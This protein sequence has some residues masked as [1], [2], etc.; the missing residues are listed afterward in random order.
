MKIFNLTRNQLIAR[1]GKAARTYFERFRGLI[2][3]KCF[4]EDDG[5]WIPKCQG[6]HTFGM[7]FPIDVVFLD[8]RKKVVGI[9]KD[10][11]P[12]CVGPVFLAAHSVLEFAAGTIERCRIRMGDHFSLIEDQPGVQA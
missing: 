5:L 12:N 10:L 4:G 3:T 9:R 6:V 8:A 2:G 7:A 1:Q 11:V